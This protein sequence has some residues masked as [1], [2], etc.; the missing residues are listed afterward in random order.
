MSMNRRKKHRQDLLNTVENAI[1]SQKPA[2]Q[3]DETDIGLW[4]GRNDHH[5]NVFNSKETW[6]QIRNTRPL[7]EDYKGIW[8]PYLTPKYSFITWLVAKNRVTTGAR[9][10]KWNRQADSSCIFCQD[11]METWE[12]LFFLCPFSFQVWR[13]LA[14]GILTTDFTASWRDILKLIQGNDLGKTKC[15]ILRDNP[16]SKS[17]GTL[18]ISYANLVLLDHSRTPVWSKNLTRTVKSP[19][20]A[21]LLDNGNFVLRDSKINYQN[22]FLWQS[23]DYPV[24]T[25]LPEMKIGRDLKTGYETFLKF[26]LY[27]SGP[28]NG[29]GFSGIPTMQNRSYSDV[30]NNFID[31]REEV[32][33]NF[34]VTDHSTHYVRLTLTPEGLYIRDIQMGYNIIG[35]ELVLRFTDREMR[36]VPNM[37]S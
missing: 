12:H 19:V 31:N 13:E 35:M 21:E 3:N 34:K 4:K 17:I 7:M 14:K 36:F 32:A 30:V 2:Q 27:Q 23:F 1:K 16:L 37:W 29:V 33:Y 28:W 18:K 20:V 6:M 5:R 25:L 22:R 11:P 26:L 8:F 10:L 24:D 15:L 9:M